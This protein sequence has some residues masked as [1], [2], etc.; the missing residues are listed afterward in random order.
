MTRLS[1]AAMT[2]AMIAAAP[3]AAQDRRP[4]PPQPNSGP[5]MQDAMGSPLLTFAITEEVKSAPDRASVGAGV[6]TQAPTAVEAMRLNATA[7]ERVIRAIRARGIAERDIQTTGINLSPQ[8][9][10]SGQQNGQPP[11]FIGYQVSNQVRVTT[12]DIA[13]LG[14]L[15]DTLVEAGGTN[16]DGPNFFLADPDA[17]LDGAR[18][19]A[20]RRA[21][22]RAARYARLAGYRS[23]QLV[24]ISEGGGMVPPP[25]P[26]YRM[27]VQASSATP[28]Q[29]GQVSNA[30]TINV[31]YRLE[32]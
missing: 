8:Y 4:L 22:E 23:A 30:L 27:D 1:L 32:R 24:A 26:M 21:T 11:R 14:T 5:I 19:I 9:D 25:M 3:A 12:A 17:N 2:L 28:V 7:M 15:L 10:Y 16:I 31:Q 29:P 6:T 18:E 13:R 20:L